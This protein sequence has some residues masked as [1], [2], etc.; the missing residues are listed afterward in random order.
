MDTSYSANFFE[1][2]IGSAFAFSPEGAEYALLLEGVECK[3]SLNLGKYHTFTLFFTSSREVFFPQ[4]TYPLK[5][6]VL[7][8]HSIFITAISE[9]ETT[10]RYQ[11]PFSVIKK[12]PALS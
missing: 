3:P 4:G 7:G 11:A 10:Y 1:P 2:H 12:E 9:S 6:P 5:H 8:E